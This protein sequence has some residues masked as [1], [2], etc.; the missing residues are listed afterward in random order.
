MPRAKAR[1]LAWT[2]LTSRSG[3]PKNALAREPHLARLWSSYQLCKHLTCLPDAGGLLDQD[4]EW[5]A[6]AGVFAATEADYQESQK[7][8]GR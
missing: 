5:V 4:A 8:K 3:T 1:R 6:F 2:V 7:P